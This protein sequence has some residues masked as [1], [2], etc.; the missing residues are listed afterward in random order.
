MMRWLP[1]A[2]AVIIVAA[3]IAITSRDYPL[4]GHDYRYFVPRL[5]D[6]DLHL[7][8]NGPSIQWYT[9]SFGGGLPAFP[10]PQ[11][12]QYSLVQLL[13]LFV[14][15]WNAILLA[16][17]GVN[18]A[19]FY[20]F[21]RFARSQL[22]MGP[23]AATLGAIF[24]I[25]NG[26]SIERLIVGHVGFH[27]FPLSALVLWALVDR[28]ESDLTRGAIAG[29]A[30]VVTMYHAG[31]LLLIVM[32]LTVGL[33][34]PL[35]E[36]LRAGAIDLRRV[37]RTSGVALVFGILMSAPKIVAALMLMR[38][39]PREVADHPSGSFL[40]GLGGLAAQ[41]AGVGTLTPLLAVA[42][43]D[44]ARVHGLYLKFIDGAFGIWE[45]DAGVSPILLVC[46]VIGGW[47]TLTAWRKGET[48]RLA[49]TQRI[50]LLGLAIASWIAIESALAQGVIYPLLKTLPV[51]SALHVNPRLAGAFILPLAIAAAALIDRVL[52]QPG[53]ESLAIGMIVA[54]WLAPLPYFVLPAQLHLRTFDLSRSL[55]DHA[56]VR[57]G[58]RFTIDKLAAV[59]D[60]D[61]F[62]SRASSLLPYDPLL[63]Y[64]NEFFT[65]QA[66]AGDVRTVEDGY[67]NM[68]N[69]AS[70]VF[71]ELNGLSPFERIREPDLDRLEQFVSRRQ[72]D[73]DRPVVLNAL[74]AVA[75]IAALVCASIVVIGLRGKAHGTG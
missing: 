23:A 4:V 6:T 72:P 42:N 58:E 70:L 61:G 41:L 49:R 25:G 2:S 62:A 13:T 75:L 16:A 29:L 46:F 1:A 73:W 9:P 11:H 64:G 31:A 48:G 57:Q 51:F 21:Y 18:L 22:G 19:G 56:A 59:S 44:V 7:R 68:T 15:P 24:F 55:A 38:Q 12:L 8:V 10:N 67:L 37:V 74:V 71:A 3:M 53:R 5:I 43:V 63:G 52:K 60:A 20:C 66:R 14:N 50:A 27:L 45:L 40:Q 33:C 47:S 54:S 69:P 28:R 30:I 39:F 34:L 65:P 32:A 17:I 35:V 26:F 36:V